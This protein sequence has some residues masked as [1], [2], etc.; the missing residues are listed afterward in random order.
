MILVL[1]ARLGW[2]FTGGRKLPDIDAG[3]IR[4]LAKAA[5]HGLYLLLVIACALGLANAVTRGSHVFDNFSFPKLI[6]ASLKGR[7]SE[8]HE[9]SANLLLFLA[10][11]HAGAA[12]WHHFV[13]RDGVLRRMAPG[14]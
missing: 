3:W 1:A 6:D 4:I 8:L 14:L 12:L 2:R 11:A 5:H 7:I 9:W 10:L 13:A